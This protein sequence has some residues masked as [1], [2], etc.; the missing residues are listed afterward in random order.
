METE[1][2]GDGTK[3]ESSLATSRTGTSKTRPH[4]AVVVL[5][6]TSKPENL[7]P[8]LRRSGRFDREVCLGI[9]DEGARAHILRRLMKGMRLSEEINVE[10]IARRS[11]GYVGADLTALTKEAAVCSVHRVFG[12]VV[13]LADVKAAA[14]GAGSMATNHQGTFAA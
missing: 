4:P 3:A 11:P 14:S 5:G 8:G 12:S 10:D 1:T 9:P 7:D 13:A 6:A 2:D